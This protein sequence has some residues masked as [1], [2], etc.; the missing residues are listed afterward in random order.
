MTNIHH[1]AN[2]QNPPIP[3]LRNGGIVLLKYFLRATA[4]FEDLKKIEILVKS[5]ES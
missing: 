3:P 5:W 1:P 2:E 4:F